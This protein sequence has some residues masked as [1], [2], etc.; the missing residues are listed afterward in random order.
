MLLSQD[1]P[2]CVRLHLIT[3]RLNA[4]LQKTLMESFAR[5]EA[6]SSSQRLLEP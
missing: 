3:L 6:V 1:I 4:S 5:E 2:F